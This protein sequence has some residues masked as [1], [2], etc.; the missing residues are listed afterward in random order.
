MAEHFLKQGVKTNVIGVPK[1][2]DGGL[3]GAGTAHGPPA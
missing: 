1:T 3:A 2:I